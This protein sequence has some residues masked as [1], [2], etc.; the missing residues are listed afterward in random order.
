[1]RKKKRYPLKSNKYGWLYHN[2]KW[3]TLSEAA[4]DMCNGVTQL[5]KAAKRG[6]IFVM[7]LLLSR[8][9]NQVNKSANDG[10]TAL[11]VACQNGHEDVVKVLLKK[12]GIEV[13]VQNLAGVTPI[14]VAADRRHGKIVDLLLGTEEIRAIGWDGWRPIAT[15][16]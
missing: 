10:T 6:H 15:A 11:H 8:D 1:M 16:G 5:Y 7:K 4:C 12:E 3:D 9:V 2:G 13:N 14:A